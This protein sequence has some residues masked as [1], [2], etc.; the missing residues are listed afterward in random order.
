MD[1]PGEVRLRAARE[2]FGWSGADLAGRVRE[3]AVRRRLRSGCSRQLISDWEL[4]KKHPSEESQILLAD[5]FDVPEAM[6]QTRPWPTWLPSPDR[7][8]ATVPLN[9]RDFVKAAGIAVA[10]P[11]VTA[12]P[13]FAAE[14]T[15]LV[16]TET[17]QRLQ[18]AVLPLTTMPTVQRQHMV[19]MLDSCLTTVTGLLHTARYDTR[20]GVGLNQLAAQLAQTCGWTRFD[21]GQQDQAA[22]LWNRSLGHAKAAGDR[23]MVSSVVA[24]FAYQGIWT[25][26]PQ[27][28]VRLLDGALSR[29][30]HPTVRSLMHLR[31]ARA[32][33]ALGEGTASRHHLAKSETELARSSAGEV[34]SWA[35]WMSEADVE[36][37]GGRC[38]IDLG[39]QVP[40]TRRIDRG[41]S[42]LTKPR[43]KTYAVFQTYRAEALVH[44]GEIEEAA[45]VLTSAL[46]TARQ[47]GATR[48]IDQ[49]AQISDRL[50]GH[51]SVAGVEQLLSRVRDARTAA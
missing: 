28:S 20:T 16:G 43:S 49:V 47:I 48:C 11:T 51:R 5:A 35:A 14:R 19:A 37:D 33:A 4:G 50:H 30:M 32:H 6:V 10:L 40:G 25:N 24:D 44:E 12:Q 9:R 15:P 31:K 13:A 34:P 27:E 38:L 36:I 46:G 29:P 2:M 42:L 17:V 21:V 23:D 3:A 8:E 39:E 45:A 7:E 26:N 18:A 22:A 1:D 41:L